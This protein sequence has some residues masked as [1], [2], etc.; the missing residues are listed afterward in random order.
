[1]AFRQIVMVLR[2]GARRTAV[3]LYADDIARGSA[4][5]IVECCDR[6]M[7]LAML[8]VGVAASVV[9]DRRDVRCDERCACERHRK[10][11]AGQKQFCDISQGHFH[12]VKVQII[13]R[14]D[15][16]VGVKMAN[17]KKF[18]FFTGR[19]E[20]LSLIFFVFLQNRNKRR[21]YGGRFQ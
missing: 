3:R 9:G 17:W 19:R 20:L 8:R 6:E 15:E 1:M 12:G 7:L 4:W 10:R 21:I 16:F 2:I 11:Y 18:C 5:H 14:N 13:M